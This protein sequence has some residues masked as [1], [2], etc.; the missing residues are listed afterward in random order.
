[1]QADTEKIY[2]KNRLPVPSTLRNY[3][4]TQTLPYIRQKGGR[5]PV[6]AKNHTPRISTGEN[7]IIKIIHAI[8]GR[9]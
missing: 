5:H 7:K 1:M 6:R 3:V 4:I 2:R 9:M 8:N